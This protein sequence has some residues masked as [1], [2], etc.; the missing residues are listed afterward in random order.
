[1]PIYRARTLPQL[2]HDLDWNGRLSNRLFLFLSFIAVA[3][4]TVG[5]YAVTTHAV[6]RERHEIGIRMALGAR[7]RQIVARVVRRL[8]V[9]VSIGFAAGV[10]C[11]SLWDRTFPQDTTGQGRRR[12]GR[13][14]RLSLAMRRSRPAGIRSPSQ[15]FC[16]ARRASRVDPLVAMRADEGRRGDMAGTKHPLFGV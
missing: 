10:V 13:P 1:M 4:A 11:T 15:R 6:S 7:A 2:R 12:S 5:L 8:L 16:R 9:Q 14:I 3:L